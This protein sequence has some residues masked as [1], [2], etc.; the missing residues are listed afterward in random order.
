MLYAIGDSFTY[1]SNFKI[2]NERIE[3]IWPSQL[4]NLLSLPHNNLA[5]P[6]GSNWRMAR[7]VTT[8][9]LN[10][11]DVVIIAL[12]DSRR[13]EFGVNPA[14]NPPAPNTPGDVN[15][16]SN[17]TVTKRFFPS[18]TQRT[19]DNHAKTLTDLTFGPF[20]N[21]QW[22]IQM[23]NVMCSAIAY[24]LQTVGCRWLMFDAWNANPRISGIDIPNY[25]FPNSTMH[26]NVIQ[27]KEGDVVRYW[28]K[29][30]HTNVAKIIH[31][32]IINNHL[33]EYEIYS[34]NTNLDWF[35]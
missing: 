17:G 28:S 27:R 8:L 20:F 11:D 3:S 12:S 16:V 5:I 35:Y 30:D 13:F 34:A 32:K 24:R 14:Y 29:E 1:G 25:I 15:E 31:N 10:S 6:G 18:L 33:N 23:H 4:A 2:E 26:D 9:Q 22:Y 7:L 21:L 19:T